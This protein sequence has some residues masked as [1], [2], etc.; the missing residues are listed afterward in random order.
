M[1]AGKN[2]SFVVSGNNGFSGKVIWQEEYDVATKTSTLSI[3]LQLMSATYFSASGNGYRTYYPDGTIKVD[4]TTALEMKSNLGTHALEFYSLNT[5]R[6]IRSNDSTKYPTLPISYGTIP[7]NADGSKSVTIAVSLYLGTQDGQGGHGSFVGGS[8]TIE[9]TKIVSNAKPIV[10][11]SVV[12]VNSVTVGLTGDSSKLVKYYSNAQATMTAQA[13]DGAAIDLD[14]L[15][16]T[17]GGSVGYGLSHTFNDIESNTFSFSA[18]DSNGN[19]GNDTVTPTMVNYV[20]LTCNYISEMPDGSGS[21]TVRCNGN[22]FNGSF[23]AVNNTLTVKYRYKT[24]TGSY[25]AWQ[26]MTFSTVGNTYYATAS[27]TGL[28]YQTRYTFQC[29][30]SDALAVVRSGEDTVKSVPVFHWGED[31]FVF[32]VPVT[33]NA[34]VTGGGNTHEGDVSITGNL[35]LKGSGNYGN[36]LYFGDGEYCYL[37]EA[38]DD[39]LTI[40]ATGLY[41]NPTNLYLNG[42]TVKFGSWTP[43]LSSSSAVSSYTVRQGW[44]QKLGNVVTI[45]WQVKAQ[46]NSGYHSTAVS[47][48]GVPFTPSYAAFGG[49]IAHNLY[50]STGYLFEGWGVSDS[51]VITAR[52]QP[53]TN[54]GNINIASSSFYPNGGGVL[55]VASTICYITSS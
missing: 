30:A 51:G 27:L 12:D 19:I 23:G 29:E 5:W 35:R 38:T 14:S 37:K 54:G 45:G 48:S 53:A 8:Q 43:T 24:A 34:G 16:I 50:T 55:T 1:A 46:I 21:M 52:L 41:L 13:Q 36:A 42:S 32:E 33:F 4:G 2:G 44:Y 49:G 26:S 39:S 6:N 31:D 11:G 40:K 20:K 22:Y 10:S 15:V 7:H 47:I 25:G 3:N 17:N 28:D 18:A 9:L